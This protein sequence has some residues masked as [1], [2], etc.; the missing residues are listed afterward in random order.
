[1]SDGG[2]RTHGRERAPEP[3][4]SAQMRRMKSPRLASV[5]MLSQV[6]RIPEVEIANLRALDAHNTKEMSRRHLECL[7]VRRRRRMWVFRQSLSSSVLA[8]YLRDQLRPAGRES[9]GSLP[10]SATSEPP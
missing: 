4:A 2:H 3:V 10:V 8:S 5:E 9:A 7:G 1:M 6:M